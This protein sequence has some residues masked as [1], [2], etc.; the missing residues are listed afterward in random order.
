MKV[1]YLMGVILSMVLF[2]KLLTLP[3]WI[4]SFT[5]ILSMVLFTKL[6]T[7]QKVACNA[8]GF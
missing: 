2:T 3:L 8:F 6:L 4:S 1:D 7:F 5:V